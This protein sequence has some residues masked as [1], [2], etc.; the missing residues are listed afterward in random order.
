[1]L[2]KF[3]KLHTNKVESDFLKLGD[4]QKIKTEDPLLKRE[5]FSIT[6]RKKKKQ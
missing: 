6:L 4:F 3:E 2:S 1:M 5:Q